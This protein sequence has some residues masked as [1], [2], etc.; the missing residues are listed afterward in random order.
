[1]DVAPDGGRIQTNADGIKHE[2]RADGS[3]FQHLTDGSIIEIDPKSRNVLRITRA[4]SAATDTTVAA[5]SA[6]ASAAATTPAADAHI[7]NHYDD[8]SG[9]WYEH[10]SQTGET[11]WLTT[12]EQEQANVA[13]STAAAADSTTITGS[14]VHAVAADRTAAIEREAQQALRAMQAKIDTAVENV[15]TLQRELRQVNQDRAQ[16]RQDWDRTLTQA[17]DEKTATISALQEE[18]D[19]LKCIQ[20]DRA[21]VASNDGDAAAAKVMTLEA[22]LLELQ[23]HLKQERM[24]RANAM[25]DLA[26]IKGANK[27]TAERLEETRTEVHQT[28]AQLV[29]ANAELCALRG[30]YEDVVDQAGQVAE[31]VNTLKSLLDDSARAYDASMAEVARLEHLVAEKP[32]TT[33]MTAATSP[34]SNKQQSSGA[35]RSDAQ[36]KAAENM[37]TAT[38]KRLQAAQTEALQNRSM[39]EEMQMRRES[40]EH[41]LRRQ[42]S[43]IAERDLQVQGLREELGKSAAAHAKRARRVESD[44]R[45]VVTRLRDAICQLEEELEAA[46]QKQAEQK[47]QSR[48]QPQTQAERKLNADY[49]AAKQLVEI[50]GGRIFELE[51]SLMA[52]DD[53]VA[54][55]RHDLSSLGKENATLRTKSRSESRESVLTLEALKFFDMPSFVPLDVAS[56][57]HADGSSIS[58]QDVFSV[59]EQSACI[60]GLEGGADRV[61]PRR[62][63]MKDMGTHQSPVLTRMRSGS[64]HVNGR[65]ANELCR[66]AS[67]EKEKRQILLQ[68]RLSSLSLTENN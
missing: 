26:S 54:R 15:A 16:E 55:I 30:K 6:A 65:R 51:Q 20:H 48:S 14:A 61:K 39:L 17:R 36:L 2:V 45:I 57:K 9:A 25:A 28:K 13:A 33:P 63:Q 31:E 8:A 38:I 43:A 32:E 62:P 35:P 59:T 47:L 46:A 5:A 64:L 40:S 27:A 34:S 67:L 11:R 29:E 19:K 24:L 4:P 66:L 18:L 21:E 52:K 42:R 53:E 37:V 56:K 22:G 10:N 1:V 41:L 3:M 68:K 49:A 50:Q 12:E 44:H 58:G 60:G 7:Q 23:T